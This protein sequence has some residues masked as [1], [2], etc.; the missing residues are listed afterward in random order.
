VALKSKCA[1]GVLGRDPGSLKQSQVGS[2]KLT[3]LMVSFDGIEIPG[4][5][6][7]QEIQ[8]DAIRFETSLS[9]ML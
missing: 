5:R 6:K 7:R 8:K 3:A 9:T 4:V 2:F 1:P